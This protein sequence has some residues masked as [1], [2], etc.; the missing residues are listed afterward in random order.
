M[1]NA[2]K[3]ADGLLRALRLWA[4]LNLLRLKSWVFEI[5]FLSGQEMTPPGSYILEHL[6]PRSSKDSSS[7]G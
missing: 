5:H 7:C 2:L 1:K 6:S 3:V 4:L